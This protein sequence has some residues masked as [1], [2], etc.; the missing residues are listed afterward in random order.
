MFQLKDFGNFNTKRG[1]LK[2][3][4]DVSLKY[5]NDFP[6]DYVDWL[7][8]NKKAFPSMIFGSKEFG[9]GKTHLSCAVAHRILDRWNGENVPCPIYFISEGDIYRNIIATYSY[10]FE[11]KIQKD[12]EDDIIKHLIHLPLLIIDDL[13]KE[14]RNDLKFVQRIM[15]NLIDGRYMANR[16][17]IITTNMNGEEIVRYLGDGND[18]ACY[19]RLVEMC[20]GNIWEITAESYRTNP[21]K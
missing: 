3:I 4:Y 1:N 5:A 6:I 8:N 13:G 10:S 12:S 16:P 14:I 11:E 7:R 9:A 20:Q 18:S 19:N 15:F 2:K 21:I 17:V